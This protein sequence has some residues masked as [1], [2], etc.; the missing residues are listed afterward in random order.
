MTANRIAVLGLGAWGTAVSIMLVRAGHSVTA[1]TVEEPVA[2]EI[3]EW[4]SNG[5]YLPGIDTPPQLQATLEAG[6]ALAGAEFVIWALPTQVLRSVGAGV[7]Q[8][9][10]PEAVMVSLA[11]GFELKSHAR[12]TEVLEQTVPACTAAA[13]LG[14]SHAE[15]VARGVPTVVAACSPDENIAQRLQDLF[16]S[17]SFRVYR[18]TDLLGAECAT[19]LKNIMAV[20]AGISD[21]LG[22]GDNTKGALLTRG[23][24]E[25]SRLG[26]A[27]GGRRETFYGLTGA[28]DLVTTSFSRHSRNRHVGEEIGKG[29]PLATVLEEMDQVAEGVPT[30]RAALEMA[31]ELDI[32]VPITEQ[33][34]AVLFE[35][36]PPREAM[37]D[38]M[39]R[40][41]RPE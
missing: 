13:L 29:R 10:P 34:V 31:R 11:K 39:A 20:A 17:E 24:A 8:F 38:L 30:S 18:N 37:L 32:D 26:V 9:V 2:R 6:E 33:V 28:G 5:K 35:D 19:A 1:W 40:Q 12:P 14:P 23:L 36:K 21:G 7:G 16:H 27:L 3:N 15:E 22:Y 25:M 41:P 4:R